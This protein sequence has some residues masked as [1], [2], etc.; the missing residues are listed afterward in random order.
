MSSPSKSCPTHLMWSHVMSQ[1]PQSERAVLNSYVYSGPTTTL[2]HR[3]GSLSNGISHLLLSYSFQPV[4]VL[5]YKQV[6][7]SE[8]WKSLKRWKSSTTSKIT[9]NRSV[10]RG[11]YNSELLSLTHLPLFL[12]K[13]TFLNVKQHLHNVLN[14]LGIHHVLTEP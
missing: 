2:W 5:N 3:R 1:N 11:V 10:Q 4:S 12:F 8:C 13:K 9:Q 7:S 14:V 6:Q